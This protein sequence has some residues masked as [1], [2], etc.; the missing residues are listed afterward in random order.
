MYLLQ[1]RDFFRLLIFLQ[2]NLI[3]ELLKLILREKRFLTTIS[4][5]VLLQV[6]YLTPSLA[7]GYTIEGPHRNP[8]G[9]VSGPHLGWQRH[10]PTWLTHKVT[11]LQRVAG[12]ELLPPSR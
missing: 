11:N 9:R 6:R 5:K 2:I 7:K 3:K 8:C 12:E 4:S 1:K 10:P